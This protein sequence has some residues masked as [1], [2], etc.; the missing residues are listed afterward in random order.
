M[1]MTFKDSDNNDKNDTNDNTGASSVKRAM[2]RMRMTVTTMTIRLTNMTIMIMTAMM[3]KNENIV[4]NHFY[5]I[6]LMA[7]DDI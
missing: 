5:L 3:T 7:V 4:K 6:T 2:I 1:T